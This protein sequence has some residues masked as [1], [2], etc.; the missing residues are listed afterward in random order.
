[1]TAIEDALYEI[2]TTLKGDDRVFPALIPE[3]VEPTD[4]SPIVFWE[5][6]EALRMLAH[7]GDANL[8]RD[9]FQVN[10]LAKEYDAYRALRR[11]LSDGA[12]GYVAT[13]GTIDVTSVEVAVERDAPETGAELFGGSLDLIIGWKE[14]I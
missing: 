13:H 12:N 5:E 2:L 4:A 9:R 11:T 3:G 8:H 7:S 1:M 10:I 6:V 14:N